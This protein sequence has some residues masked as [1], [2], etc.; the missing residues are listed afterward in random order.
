M[1]YV[2]THVIPEPI[3]YTYAWLTEEGIPY[4]VGK[5]KDDRA[6]AG[7]CGHTLPQ[8]ERI[9]I[10]KSGLTEFDAYKHEMFVIDALGRKD[11]GTGIL[12]N[13]SNGGEGVSGPMSAEGRAKISK[14]L[15]GKPSLMRGWTNWTNGKENKRSPDC[16]GPGWRR[17]YTKNIKDTTK[18]RVWWTNG[19]KE[20]KSFTSPGEG[21]RRGRHPRSSTYI[22][23]ANR[24]RK[25]RA[26]CRWFTNG[27]NNRICEESP[28]DGWWLGLTKKC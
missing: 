5:G 12:D 22:N 14:A 28:G 2:L 25:S 16:P 18:G 17:G 24:G 21:W 23:A 19:E 9:I 11:L 13:H 26:N 6:W 27:V 7:H 3:Y 20:C 4:Y 15:T 10:L 8:K 1:T